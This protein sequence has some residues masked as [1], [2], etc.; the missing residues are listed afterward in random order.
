MNRDYRG[1]HAPRG[2]DGEKIPVKVR[3]IVEGELQRRELVRQR[4][5][6]TP[7][8]VAMAVERMSAPRHAGKAQRMATALGLTGIR[9]LVRVASGFAAE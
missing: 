1:K 3:P 7:D 8:S 2:S 5:N 9:E 4:N 6:P